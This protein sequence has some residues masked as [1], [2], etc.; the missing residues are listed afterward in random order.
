MSHS[1]YIVARWKREGRCVKSESGQIGVRARQHAH[2]QRMLLAYWLPNLRKQ[3]VGCSALRY[4]EG[5]PWRSLVVT[6]YTF[7][8]LNLPPRIWV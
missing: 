5:S 6:A 1:D 4:R 7:S 2:G 3:L 8:V